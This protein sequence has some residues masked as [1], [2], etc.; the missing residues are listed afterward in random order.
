VTLALVEVGAD[1]LVP[2]IV[3]LLAVPAQGNFAMTL[4]SKSKP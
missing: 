1:A 4:I 3:P 2:E